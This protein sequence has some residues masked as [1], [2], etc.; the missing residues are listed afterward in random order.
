ME[1][2]QSVGVRV[3]LV[4]KSLEALRVGGG[5]GGGAAEA[6]RHAAELAHDLKVSEPAAAGAQV[7]AE[8]IP[9][10]HV[11]EARLLGYSV[12]VHLVR[13]R[14]A[15][16]A[17]DEKV[18]IARLAVNA[19]Y[20]VANVDAEGCR[21]ESGQGTSTSG[22][23]SNGGGA[24]S[25]VGGADEEP[26]VMKSM[27]ASLCAEVIR[28]EGQPALAALLPEVMKITSVGP[29]QAGI[30][31]LVL[32]TLAEEVMVYN[33][34]LEA[35]RLRSLFGALTNSLPTI[36]PAIY[37]VMDSNFVHA[38]KAQAAGSATDVAVHLSAVEMALAAAAAYAEWAPM[39][40]IHETR[41][42]SA[43]GHLIQMESMKMAACEFVMQVASRKRAGDGDSFN[44]GIR[45]L[46]DALIVGVDPA[47]L[48]FQRGTFPSD[49]HLAFLK[50]FA[51]AL[52]AMA[53]NHFNVGG[54]LDDSQREKLGKLLFVLSQHPDMA[55]ASVGIQ[56][57]N[58]LV[59]SAVAQKRLHIF[60][61]VFMDPLLQLI[62]ERV[63]R[64]ESIEEYE[65]R[66]GYCPPTD[67]AAEFREVYGSF[68]AK[69]SEL[70]KLL[71]KHSP[72]CLSSC[73][74]HVIALLDQA[75]VSGITKDLEHTIDGA[76]QLLESV[77]SGL[78]EEVLSGQIMNASDG[79][80]NSIS[81]ILSFEHPQAAGSSVF[82]VHVA[83]CIEAL[84]RLLQFYPPLF[85]AGVSK[86]MDT[87]ISIPVAGLTRGYP[88]L[89][90]CPHVRESMLLRQRVALLMRKLAAR[91]SSV[92]VPHIEAIA[93][94]VEELLA[95]DLV[96]NSEYAMMCEMLVKI[97][98]AESIERQTS[99]L[100]WIFEPIRKRWTDPEFLRSLTD[101]SAFI[102]Q[103]GAVGAVDATGQ[104]TIGG[105][106]RRWLVFSDI[107]IVE[108][109]LRSLPIPL[110]VTR[111]APDS[112]P[113]F[114]G[115]MMPAILGIIRCVHLAW[116]PEGQ[117][118]LGA[119]AA[120]TEP[121]IGEREVLLGKSTLDAIAAKAAA[122]GSV[123]DDTVSVASETVGSLRAWFRS[124]RDSV[125]A[126]LGNILSRSYHVYAIPAIGSAI[127][128]ALFENIDAVESRHV[129]MIVRLVLSGA[130]RSTPVE[131]RR[132]FLYPIF[133]VSLPHIHLRLSHAWLQQSFVNEIA[134][135][136]G[137]ST[138]DAG[139]K[140][141]AVV[142]DAEILNAR[143]LVELSRDY[144]SFLQDLLDVN[145]LLKIQKGL[146]PIK[147]KNT[148][149]T[150][151]N[152]LQGGMLPQ[153]LAECEGVGISV[154]QFVRLAMRAPDFETLNR[155]VICA[156]AVIAVAAK[157]ARL[158]DEVGREMFVNLLFAVS[159][160]VNA[161]LL[162][163]LYSL[164]RDILWYFGATGLPYEVFASI[165]GVT[166]DAVASLRTQLAESKSE[167]EQRNL[168]KA[169]VIAAGGATSRES[170]AKLTKSL[171]SRSVVPKLSSVALYGR[172]GATEPQAD[173]ADEA[174]LP[175]LF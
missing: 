87:V 90:P 89:I 133:A 114:L 24:S 59:R 76:A 2:R 82:M 165:P 167:K 27:S 171:E 173:D 63:A 153:L 11:P 70:G 110:N 122:A 64:A 16:F 98:T 17:P 174:S 69:F 86:L 94:R 33:E 91:K 125:Y 170:M 40:A 156:R 123:D 107:Q 151:V 95:K 3:E 68:R 88:P 45:E 25:G 7:A 18:H 136:G 102:A 60:P 61:P 134:G 162:A 52:N 74:R 128:S 157:D 154:V 127:A 9:R 139:T 84:S 130:A 126:S 104:P 23:G 80:E 149:N 65:E 51:E 42:I 71:G 81:Y 132:S 10:R 73:L 159:S 166:P 96:Q 129:R 5:A 175:P 28:A 56:S 117:S 137:G 34:G 38:Q 83:R 92:L 37:S 21:I 150:S 47:S 72:S 144:C 97:A 49:E 79:V 75:K 118:I 54:P 22:N 119:A 4:L 164:M 155:C 115:W 77:L 145:Q 39:L 168:I 26:W 6:H 57:W 169:F 100:A 131:H 120:A 8:L 113:H 108:S 58:T 109:S 46:A 15:S 66:T 1:E 19:L 163:D 160:E 53:S 138:N 55:V 103:F 152:S 35:D 106:E 62:S 20:E 158:N 99:V 142:F 116:T 78:P 29:M 12:L 148:A 48:A 36:L 141:A 135:S 32:K 105:G 43:A 121:C 112:L 140:Q 14:W 161:N 41:L 85:I 172:P 13:N 124:I 31:C 146:D 111:D 101:F 143:S 44:L 30:V 50:R 67:S 93:K 147:L